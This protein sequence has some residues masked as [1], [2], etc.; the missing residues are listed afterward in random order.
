MISLSLTLTQV[1]LR[2]MVV[3]DSGS[4]GA[5]DGHKMKIKENGRKK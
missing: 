4:M 2:Y 1:P 3:D 5:L